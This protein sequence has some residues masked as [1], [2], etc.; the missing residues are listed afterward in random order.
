M[1]R[2]FSLLACLMLLCALIAPG[3]A[4]GG[5]GRH[6]HAF[7]GGMRKTFRGRLQGDTIRMSAW[8]RARRRHRD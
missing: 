7:G 2:R 1:S 3:A 5:S 8:E 6:R 4:P